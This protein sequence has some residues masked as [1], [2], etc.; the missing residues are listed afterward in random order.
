MPNSEKEPYSVI[1]LS[2]SHPARRKILRML[3]EKPRNF[4]TILETLGISSSHLTYHLENLGELVTK[5]DDGRYKLSTFGEAAVMAMRRVEETPGTPQIRK[6][7]FSLRWKSL[8]AFLAIGII[9]LAT[10][11]CVQYISLNQLSSDYQQ[12]SKNYELLEVNFEQV[13]QENQRLL[14]LGMSPDR[15]LAFLRNVVYL[16]MTKYYST[17]ESNTVEY[18]SDWGGIIEE[19]SKYSLTY[20]GSKVDVTFR[21]RNTTLSSYYLYVIEGTPYYSQLQPNNIIEAAENLIERYQTYSGASHLESMK[22]ILKTVEEVG[23]LER[24]SGNLKLIISTEANNIKIQFVYTSN[25]IDFQAKSLV[26]IFD[27]YG[28]LK[29]LS[30]D[31]S[32]YKVDSTEVNIS[33]EEAINIAIDYASNYSWIANGEV[34]NGFT[35]VTESASARLWPHPREE[36]LALIPYWY[37]TIYLDRIYPDRV[38][39]LAVGVWA[40]TGEV[41]ICQTLSW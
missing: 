39:R 34:I 4:S 31:W 19:I 13:S 24:T 28:F 29:S 21:F 26:L 33:M 3:S 15:V 41:S 20:E 30:D 5:L 23:E 14:S 22:N 40:D 27:E 38:D 9:I 2:L 16:D 6:L 12:V 25:D 32:L 1:F 36:P 18:R 11:S 37:V 10:V 8:F 7:P 35:L 17:L